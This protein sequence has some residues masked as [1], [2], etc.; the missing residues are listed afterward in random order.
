VKIRAAAGRGGLGSLPRYS[1]GLSGAGGRG[2]GWLVRAVRD[3]GC[4]WDAIP[5][6]SLALGSLT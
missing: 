2:V 1:G 3:A 5:L 4:S 6:A